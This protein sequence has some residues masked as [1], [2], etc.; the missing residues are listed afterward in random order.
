MATERRI[1]LTLTPEERLAV[2]A[3]C[4]VMYAHLA[5]DNDPE[6]APLLRVYAGVLKQIEEREE[7]ERRVNMAVKKPK[8]GSTH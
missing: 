2:G 5:E 7:A 3:A 4:R 6:T 1:Q 8:L